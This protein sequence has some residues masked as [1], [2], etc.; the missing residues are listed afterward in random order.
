MFIKLIGGG[1]TI[2]AASVYGRI[3]ASE[4]RKRFKLLGEFILLV[5]FVSSNIEHFKTPLH[6]I[7]GDFYTENKELLEFLS[8]AEKSGLREAWQQAPLKLPREVM[9]SCEKFAN[10]LGHGYFEDELCTY[11]LKN[12][13]EASGKLES[14]LNERTKM[15]STLPPLLASSVLLIIL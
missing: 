7:L 1:I 9:R 12:L 15:W 2:F 5:K 8:L 13:T 6:M 4:E 10:E 14:E 3:K 11:T